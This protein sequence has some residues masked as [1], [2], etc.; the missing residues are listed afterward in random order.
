MGDKV[1]CAAGRPNAWQK[2]MCS[3]SYAAADRNL[4]QHMVR[5]RRCRMRGSSPQP[6]DCLA[7][8]TDP[9]R[10]VRSDDPSLNAS[11]PLSQ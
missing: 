8:A 4:V 2:P 6:A 11:D 10:R 9:R 3:L 1:D 7:L 5:Y